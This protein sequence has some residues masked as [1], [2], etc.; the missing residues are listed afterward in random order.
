M[1]MV[2]L[3]HIREQFRLSPGSYAL[4]GRV[5][6]RKAPRMAGLAWLKS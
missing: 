3:A 2:F 6:R 1:D 4:H 5:L